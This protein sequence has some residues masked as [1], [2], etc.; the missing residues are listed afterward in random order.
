MNG[1]FIMAGIGKPHIKLALLIGI[2]LLILIVFWLSLPANLFKSPASTVVLDHNGELLGARIAADG[3]WRFPQMDSIPDNY[4]ISAILFEDEYFF[5]HPGINPVSLFHAI[6]EN[7]KSGKIV[8]GGSTISMQT[9]RL[10]RKGKKRT[11]VEKLVE[12][13]LALRLEAGFTK[14]EILR[15]YASNAPFGGNVV[16]LEA[17][18]W[19][20]FRRDPFS[21]SWAEAAT[22]AVLPNSPSLIH[23]GKNRE[24]LLQKRN[25]L[26]KKLLV[27]EKIDS[28]DYHLSL[29]EELPTAPP[30]LPDHAYHLT[31][32]YSKVRPG[33]R[34]ITGLEAPLQKKVN[35][36]ME[37]QKERLY[38]NQIRNAACIIVNNRTSEVISYYGNI[39]NTKNPAFGGDVDI[40][41]AARSSGSILKPFL[42]AEMLSRGEILPNTLVADIPTRFRA[43]NPLNFDHKFDGVVKASEALSRSLNVPAVRMLNEYGNERFHHDLKEIGF[44]TLRFSAAH[45][46]LSLILGGA[47]V[48]LWDLAAAYSG[49]ARTLNHYTENSGLY[50]RKDWQK[51]SLEKERSSGGTMN[52]QEGEEQGKM[53]AGAIWICLE[54]LR[55][56]NRP[57]SETGWQFFSNN[58]RIAWKTGT[59]FGFRDAWAIGLNPDYT[60]AVW[61]GNANGEGRPGL[62]GLLAAAPVLFELVNLLPG[63]SWFNIPYD[64]LVETEVCS[65]SGHKAGMHC[66]ETEKILVPPAGLNTRPCPYHQIIHLTSDK[67]YRVNSQCYD[68]RKMVHESWFILPP[69]QEWFYHKVNPLFKSL[70]PMLPGCREEEKIKHMQLIYPDPGSIIYIPKSLDGTKNNIIFESTHRN[71]EKNIF[72]HIDDQFIARTQYFHQISIQPQKGKHT[73]TLVDEDGNSLSIHFEIIERSRKVSD[74]KM[75]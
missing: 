50:F 11:I 42:F 58:R 15:L 61:V 2:P 71:P 32:W 4:A 72:W 67:K 3:Q 62:T 69:A 68:L 17:A 1:K 30:L 9:I 19:R 8:R 18:S 38:A 59:S 25:R 73:L 66:P 5:S 29:L 65:R 49:M 57:E 48:S 51:P 31:A 36:V 6:G 23:P 46:G 34:V 14:K 53:N 75:E 35:Q 47:E 55:K 7:I 16:G 52:I 21:L 43:F 70:P 37:I 28:T 27:K 20:Y 60:I 45:Y 13:F 54:A 10:Q 24:I 63:G 74:R 64:D 22:L 26:L 40:I 33:S 44:T 56:V 39:R 41:R 12:M